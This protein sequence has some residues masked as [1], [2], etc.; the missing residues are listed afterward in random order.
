MKTLIFSILITTIAAPVIFACNTPA[1]KAEAQQISATAAAPV[2]AQ[3]SPAEHTHSENDAAE[4][5]EAETIAAVQATAHPFSIA[6][7]VKDYLALKNALVADNAAS[8]AAA[9]KKLFATL[10][11]VDM[12]SIPAD[13]HKDYMDIAE[14]AKENA[15]H[16]GANAG[17]IDHQREHLASLSKDISDLIAL[18]GAPQ[19]LY[20]DKCPM[21]ND[22]KGAIWISETKEIKNPYL[23]AKMLTCGSIKKEL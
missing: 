9:G 12:K 20:Q 3:T 2:N 6:S 11:A 17:K 21:F 23:G 13:K 18:F 10:Q 19:K 16:I 15:E 14:N 7:I 5:V 22:G 4:N 8:A 1:Y